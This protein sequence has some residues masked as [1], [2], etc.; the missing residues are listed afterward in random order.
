MEKLSGET[1]KCHRVG[2][3]RVCYRGVRPRSEKKFFDLKA[4]ND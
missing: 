2:F 4:K 1:Q 3:H